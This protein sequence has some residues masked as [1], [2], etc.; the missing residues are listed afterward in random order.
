M[1]VSQRVPITIA[2]FH[3][4]NARGYTASNRQDDLMLRGMQVPDGW[5]VVRLA[6]VADVT[7][8]TVDKKSI[9]GEIPVRLCNYTDVFYN[10]HIEPGMDFMAATATEAEYSKWGLREGDVIFTKD[11]ETPDEI[12]VPA[13]VSET[14]PDVLCGYHLGLARPRWEHVDGAFLSKMLASRVS[15]RQFARIANGVTR[16][17]LTL[18]ATRS[19]PILLPPLSEQRDIAAV[20]DSID[21]AIE[22][23]ESVITATEHLRESLLHEL[24]TRG[25]PGL[26]T[27][28]KEVRG[29]G[30]I[31]ADWDVV[32]LGDVAEVQTGRAVNRKVTEDG[33]LEIPY[34]SVANV[35]D[36]YLDLSIVKTMVVT[37]RE[38]VRYRLRDGDVLFTE[39]GDADKL[40]RGTVWHG[41]IPLC[42]HQNH[43]FAV[44]PREGEFR[45]EFLAAFAASARGKR[46]FLGAAKQTTNLASIN[47]TQ[48]KQ[49]PLPLPGIREQARIIEML[50]VSD[51][52]I[53]QVRTEKDMLVSLKASTAHALL[54]GRL[55][56]SSEGRTF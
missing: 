44:R 21:E 23:T 17:G 43:I 30:T 5:R 46:Y 49:M 27:E 28:W 52:A 14:L 54:T 41:E 2:G 39:G 29:I 55:R 42:L 12:G 51:E 18:D 36:R 26:H 1:P 35:K 40:G 20:L 24:L 31:P 47:S 32:R 9:D 38:I 6:E 34:L 8:S 48:L 53:E 37:E 22:R 56:V 50:S 16:F 45:S 3:G 13:Y 10:R 25:V 19:L 4:G 33:G 11:S 15:A 7:F